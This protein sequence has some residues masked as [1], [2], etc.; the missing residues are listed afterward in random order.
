LAR[1]EDIVPIPGTKRRKYLDEN[2]GAVKI[3]LSESD[4]SRI[5]EVAPKGFAA[6]DRYPRYERNRSLNGA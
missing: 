3:R 6:G 5:E 2:A 1:G 4:L